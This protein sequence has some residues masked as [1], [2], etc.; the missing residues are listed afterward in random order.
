MATHENYF[1]INATISQK[2]GFQIAAGI[3]A[4]KDGS[5]TIEDPEIGVIKFYEK[6]WGYEGQTQ[7]EFRELRT[8]PCTDSDFNFE[9]NDDDKGF[10]PINSISK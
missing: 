8:K 9:D 4:Y 6:S 7:V 5:S 3:T 2:N 1:Q 10:Y